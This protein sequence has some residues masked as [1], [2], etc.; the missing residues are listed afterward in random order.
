MTTALEEITDLKPD[1]IEYEVWKLTS[2][3]GRY[4]TYAVS[5]MTF[6]EE[7]ML[8][9]VRWS[10]SFRPLVPID[11]WLIRSYVQNDFRQFMQAGLG[12]MQTA[13]ISQAATRPRRPMLSK[14]GRA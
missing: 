13:A 2:R 7:G 12:A 4:I 11:G 9:R 1:L 6:K 10:C 14:P 3:T 8:T 5:R